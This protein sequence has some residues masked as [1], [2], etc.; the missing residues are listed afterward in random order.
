[1]IDHDWPEYPDRPTLS[2]DEFRQRTGG[3]PFV[4]DWL[5]VDQALFD[6]FAAA[7]GDDAFIHTDPAKAQR[8]RFKGTIAHGLLILSLLPFML[9]SATPILAGTRMG[10]NY[11]YDR[12]RFLEPVPCDSKVRGAFSLIDLEF[13]NEGFVVI[14]F[15]VQVQIEGHEKPA[16]AARWL[17]GRWLDLRDGR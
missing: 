2:L 17:L 6:G 14:H 3:A 5:S 10:V 4:S 11:G 7:T 15:D 8:T 12:V 9:R 16:L 13:K 1:M